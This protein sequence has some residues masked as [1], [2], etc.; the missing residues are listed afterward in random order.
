MAPK[1]DATANTLRL[2]YE[3]DSVGKAATITKALNTGYDARRWQLESVSAAT[4]PLFR[5]RGW[6]Q[7]K[8]LS[9][10]QILVCRTNLICK[11]PNRINA[12]ALSKHHCQ[13]S[14]LGP[15]VTA[16]FL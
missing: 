15:T 13:P 2:E 11:A 10:F 14:F 9:L 3:L 12:A 8:K 1:L 16:F 4:A 7:L 6:A 5:G